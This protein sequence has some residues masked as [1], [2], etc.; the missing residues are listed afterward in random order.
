MITKS[1]QLNNSG[2]KSKHT[3]GAQNSQICTSEIKHGSSNTVLNHPFKEKYESMGISIPTLW[4]EKF[5]N[6][7]KSVLLNRS[8]VFC[9]F[10]R[11]FGYNLQLPYHRLELLKFFILEGGLVLKTDTPLKKKKFICTHYPCNAQIYDGANET[12]D[13][14]YEN[15]IGAKMFYSVEDGLI[16]ALKIELSGEPLKKVF[17]RNQQLL[18]A[19]LLDIIDLYAPNCKVTRLD[20]TLE[21]SHDILNIFDVLRAS[22][23][24]DFHGVKKSYHLPNINQVNI[25]NISKRYLT[26]LTI[27][28]G[29]QLSRNKK[30]RCY[31][32]FEK[33]GYHS[34]RF[35]VQNGGNRARY[36]AEKM[37]S[38]YRKYQE[39]ELK[40][41][42]DK[43]VKEQVFENLKITCNNRLQ[44]F[45]VN[46]ILSFNTLTFIANSDK[47]NNH[48]I[49]RQKH[50]ISKFW[51]EF[52]DKMKATE[53]KISMVQDKN[54]IQGKIKWFQ[55]CASSL[56]GAIEEIFGKVALIKFIFDLLDTSKNKSS[57]MG[58]KE[59]SIRET[60]KPLVGV[61]KTW[62]NNVN[63]LLDLGDKA[64]FHMMPESLKIAL[65][66]Q[67]FLS[68]Y[69]KL[70]KRTEKDG[71]EVVFPYFKPTDPA[72]YESVINEIKQYDKDLELSFTY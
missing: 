28:F 62:E 33:H 22:I 14:V 34:I 54:N 45:M 56:L 30:I 23:S 59:E 13:G 26:G 27:Y 63:E 16:Y 41:Q 65:Y 70:F 15:T 71:S 37:L 55:R 58:E 43:T 42:L 24:G 60:L 38:L 18:L 57:L 53:Y 47:K 11:A 20:T 32:T 68:D 10:F 66:K 69:P 40:N 39:E 7:D 17:P 44:S 64:W 8:Y 29:S 48:S 49:F 4:S 67:G 72:K 52:L 36:F 9:D 21:V 50:K 3:N 61:S 6:G 25:N 46:F 19:G 12:W 31:E 5:A 35:E 2:N 51:L 1:E